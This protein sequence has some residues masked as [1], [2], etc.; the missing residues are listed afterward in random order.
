[1]E[2]NG[3]CDNNTNAGDPTLQQFADKDYFVA[4]SVWG[5]IKRVFYIFFKHYWLFLSISGTIAC[6]SAILVFL[7]VLLFI[8]PLF[9]LYEE[10][11]LL[12]SYE[13]FQFPDGEALVTFAV[14]MLMFYALICVADGAIVQAVT[15]LYVQQTPTANSVLTQ[16]MLK[17]LQLVGSALV[18]GIPYFFVWA[19]LFLPQ[20]ANWAT[21]IVLLITIALTTHLMTY[22]I[23]PAIMVE[24]AHTVRSAIQRSFQL[25][26]GNIP[27]VVCILFWMWMGKTVAQLPAIALERSTN[28]IVVLCGN[29]LS[30]AVTIVFASINSMYVTR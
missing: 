14:D 18:V 10:D 28:T 25:T 7:S 2:N 19:S 26:S 24:P 23:Y 20:T 9:E 16:A 21:I 4:L 11:E 3:G 17:P 1:M 27:Y 15:E 8:K 5:T 6:I 22:P 13:F 12:N 30:I 29:I